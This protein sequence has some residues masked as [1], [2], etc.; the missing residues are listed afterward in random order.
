[1]SAADTR[2]EILTVSARLFATRGLAGTTMRA[3]ADGCSIKA[4]SLY[5]H[6]A[7]KDEIVA[8]IM[9]RSREFAAGLYREIADAHLAPAARVE[10]VL[11]ATLQSFRAHPEASQVFL[12]NPAYVASAPLLKSI[13]ADARAIDALCVRAIE[14]A[15]T[16][17]ALRDDIAPLRLWLLLRNMLRSTAR[18]AATADADDAI[19]ILLHGIAA[20]THRSGQQ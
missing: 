18:E 13:R 17:G 5:H 12:E 16:V 19:A 10:A 14:E 15:I 6:F 8:E 20:P 1:M 2:E 9:T 3:I 4:A 7:S 11:R